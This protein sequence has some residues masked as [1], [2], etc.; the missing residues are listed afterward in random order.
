MTL[1]T[2]PLT[3]AP[4]FGRGNMTHSNDK[5]SS[6]ASDKVFSRFTSH[7]SRNELNVLTTHRLIA[8]FH[9]PFTPT[10]YRMLTK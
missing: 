1:S 5:F 10:C 9:A 8:L 4:H 3:L 2:R 6:K 7:V